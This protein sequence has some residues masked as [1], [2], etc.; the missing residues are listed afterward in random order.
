MNG[1]S[2]FSNVKAQHNVETTPEARVAGSNRA[3]AVV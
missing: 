1:P 2:Y 3:E